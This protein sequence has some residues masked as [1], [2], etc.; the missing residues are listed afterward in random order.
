MVVPR[1]GAA[2]DLE[3]VRAWLETRIA[4]YKVPRELVLRPALP[5]TPSGKITKHVLRDELTR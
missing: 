4:R 3:G 1:E 2:L 5:R